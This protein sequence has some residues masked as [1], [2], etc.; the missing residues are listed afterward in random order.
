MQV[1]MCRFPKCR[2]AVFAAV[3]AIFV[4]VL[5]FEVVHRVR[6]G[7]FVGYGVH[8][9]VELGDSD[10]GRGDT[11]YAN[12]TNLS[13]RTLRL[14]GGEFPNDI[15]VK[16]DL[17]H[18]WFVQRWDD[19]AQRWLNWDFR[20]G[21]WNDTAVRCDFTGA[22]G[23][24]TRTL[25]PFQSVRHVAWVYKEWGKDDLLRIVV[26]QSSSPESAGFS[27]PAFRAPR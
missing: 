1:D 10:V 17:T 21:D 16:R 19:N 25:R 18:C 23:L 4:S 14:E 7:H 13:L 12:I 26:R 27:S 2:I 24:G 22:I 3:G 5:A 8:V 11:M 20:A 15:S 9:D 6:Y